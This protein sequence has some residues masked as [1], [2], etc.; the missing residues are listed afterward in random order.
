MIRQRSGLKNEVT[1]F[2][3]RQ[4]IRRVSRAELT[5][6]SPHRIPAEL[7]NAVYAADD[8]PPA[9]PI[10]N[11]PVDLGRVRLVHGVQ[12]VSSPVLER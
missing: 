1:V 2:L 6:Y 10:G 3:Y 8:V 5:L 9:Q 12:E 4:T 7:L 11:D